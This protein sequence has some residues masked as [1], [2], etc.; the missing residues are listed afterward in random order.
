MNSVEQAGKG[1]AK[2]MFI[3]GLLLIGFAMLVWVLK[4][5]FA[6]IAAGIF[7]LAGVWCCGLSI[8]VWWHTRKF[9][10][11]PDNGEDEYRENVRIHYHEEHF[12][13]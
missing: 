7:I 1:F 9:K 4:E 10:A 11:G 5:I 3:I 8:R 13:S 2:G 6:F 12:D